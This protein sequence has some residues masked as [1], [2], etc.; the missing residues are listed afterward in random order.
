MSLWEA[1]QP[2]V[3]ADVVR[4]FTTLAETSPRGVEG[5]GGSGALSSPLAG[6]PEKKTGERITEL[7]Q[8]FFKEVR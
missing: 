5:I 7:A 4:K 8:Y 2:A 3:D 6:Q 1:K